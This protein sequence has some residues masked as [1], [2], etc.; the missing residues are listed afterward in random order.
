MVARLLAVI[1]ALS[2]ASTAGFAEALVL[3]KRKSGTMKIREVCKTTETQLTS[4]DFAALLPCPPDSVKVASVCV[5]KYEASV[6]HL[7]G[8]FL[9]LRDKLRAGTATAA[10][11]VGVAGVTQSG[12]VSDDYSGECTDAG[13]YCTNDY[14]ASVSGVIPSQYITWPQ[15]VAICR[16]SGK[17][18]ATDQEWTAAAMATPDPGTDNGTTDCKVAGPPYDAVATGSRL[19][20]VSTMGAYDMVGNVSEW[21]ADWADDAN[22]CDNWNAAFGN[23]F[24]CYNGPGDDPNLMFP[25]SNLPHATTRGGDIFGSAAGVYFALNEYMGSAFSGLG[26]RCAR[27]M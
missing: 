15:A 4:A 3:C 8:P 17:R 12:V 10:D 9:E 16:S 5:D 14:A 21:V 13:N 23:D 6:W 24:A 18:L 22:G 2:L 26:F 20:C 19:G 11:L 1:L 27:D 7:S 25:Q